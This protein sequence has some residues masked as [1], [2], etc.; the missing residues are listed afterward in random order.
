V[1]ERQC[2]EPLETQRRRDFVI[3]Q[4]ELL[5]GERQRV[6]EPGEDV[7]L[8]RAAFADQRPRPLQF[9]EIVLVAA[10]DLAAR[11]GQ[12]RRMRVAKAIDAHPVLPRR[13]DY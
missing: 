1:L 4:C 5:G 9:L 8:I 6:L 7:D 2:L 3:G 13:K 11:I 12:V 10:K